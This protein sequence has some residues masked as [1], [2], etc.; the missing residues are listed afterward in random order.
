MERGTVSPM[1]IV[2]D[3]GD[4]RQERVDRM[5][6]EFRAAQGRL[7]ERGVNG[8]QQFV[9]SPRDGHTQAAPIASTTRQ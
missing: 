8:G 7:A 2:R 4:E 1:H 6:D 5:I 3:D 9:E